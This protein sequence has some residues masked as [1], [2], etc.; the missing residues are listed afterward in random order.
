VLISFKSRSELKTSHKFAGKKCDV[1]SAMK[2]VD[3]ESKAPTRDTRLR[4]L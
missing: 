4:L 1:T 2:E 3:Y